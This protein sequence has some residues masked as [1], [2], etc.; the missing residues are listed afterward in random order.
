M[1]QSLIQS[2]S[3]DTPSDTQEEEEGVTY[4]EG[5]IG[6]A[7]SDLESPP[8]PYEIV[9]GEKPD[10]VTAP[11]EMPEGEPGTLNVDSKCSFETPL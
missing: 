4:K 2:N 5:R 1:T 7:Y 8:P 10:E 3:E 11:A 9:V 6:F